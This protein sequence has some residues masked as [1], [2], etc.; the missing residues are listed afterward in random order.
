MGRQLKGD[1]VWF[2]LEGNG[3]DVA[4]DVSSFFSGQDDLVSASR[5]VQHQRDLNNMIKDTKRAAGMR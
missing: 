3:R 4:I 1:R 5:F 2:T